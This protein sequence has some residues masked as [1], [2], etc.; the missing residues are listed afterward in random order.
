VYRKRPIASRSR[1]YAHLAR[2]THRIAIG[3]ER[4]LSIAEGHV[5][6]RC[7]DRRHRSGASV[8]TR[9]GPEFVRRFVQHVPPWRLVRLRHF[10]LFA[11]AHRSG[12][13]A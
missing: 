10:G 1:C 8:L 5:S 6:V 7:R 4:I 9:T 2:Y 13:I 3:K 12:R 11:N